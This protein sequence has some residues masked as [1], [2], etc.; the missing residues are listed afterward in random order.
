MLASRQELSDSHEMVKNAQGAPR[1]ALILEPGST[2]HRP[3]YVRWIAEGFMT[4]GIAVTIVGPAQLLQHPEL[5]G[6]TVAGKSCAVRIAAPDTSTTSNSKLSLV[7]NER[8]LRAW[9]GAAQRA[10]AT[11]GYCDLVVVPYLDNC[12]HA[13]AALGSPFANTEWCGITMRT[14]FPNN[15]GNTAAGARLALLSRMLS[16]RSLRTL[17][18]IDPRSQPYA[19]QRSANGISKW[20]RLRYLPDPSDMVPSQTRQDARHALSLNDESHVVLLFGSI[21]PRKGLQ[22]LL[23]GASLLTCTRKWTIIIAGQHT[24]D[25]ADIVARWSARAP[26]IGFDLRVLP[27]RIDASLSA[28]LFAAA[29]VIW[30]GYPNH[31]GM[32]GVLV[33]AALCG[34]PVIG[35]NSG[36]VGE[37]LRS[38]GL[39]VSCDVSSPREVSAALESAVQPHIAERARSVGPGFFKHHRPAEFGYRLVS[40]L[41]SQPVVASAV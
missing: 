32:S 35:H 40:A 5:A 27:S 18:S 36:L 33:Q 6:I 24:A 7:R 26:A 19:R 30:T 28:T 29:D 31:K 22:E 11:R 41:D 9:Y 37:I 34:K 16:Q 14:E 13:I 25:A 21:D 38:S 4:S 2:G 8:V 1:R 15:G 20:Q 10:A 39:G 12:F 23:R 17:W 3:T